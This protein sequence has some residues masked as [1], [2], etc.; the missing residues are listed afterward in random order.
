[1]AP[2][3]KRAPKG[4]RARVRRA[5]RDYLNVTVSQE[6]VARLDTFAHGLGISRGRMVDVAVLL[7][8]K[9]LKDGTLAFCTHEGCTRMRPDGCVGDWT[10]EEH[11]SV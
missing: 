6:T 11:A 10:C 3:S 2:A 5:T 7:I 4:K 9:S 1:M 8:A